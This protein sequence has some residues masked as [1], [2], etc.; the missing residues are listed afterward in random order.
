MAASASADKERTFAGRANGAN[1]ASRPEQ[2]F[3]EDPALDR[4]M[5]VVMALATEVWVLRDRMAAIEARLADAGIV[6]LE[7]LDAEP[8]DEE[9][10]AR[11]A[12]RD[13]FVQHLMESLLGEQ[14]S[15]GAR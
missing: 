2:T 5:G 3:F 15:K 11:A 4:A 6:D 10:A 1:A 7:M 8:G 13:A 12:E 14:L 9:R